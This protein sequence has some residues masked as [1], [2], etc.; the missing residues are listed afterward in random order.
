MTTVA[1]MAASG[2]PGSTTTAAMIAAGCGRTS[3]LFEAAV[4]GGTLPG[5]GLR[6][7]PGLVS[8]AAAYPERITTAVLAEHAQMLPLGVRAVVGAPSGP[9]AAAC[10]ARLADPLAHWQPQTP[11]E[12]LVVDCG[13]V[14]A[15]SVLWPVA[16][17]ADL[18]VLVVRQ[19]DE[20]AARV[21]HTHALA[22]ALASSGARV[23]AVVIGERP[24]SAAEIAAAVG[25]PVVS[26]FPADPEAVRAALRGATG[27][28]RPVGRRRS[29]AVR[30][31]AGAMGAAV[32]TLAEVDDIDAALDV[33]A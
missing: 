22:V 16:V 31:A 27:T 14:S 21:S 2:S 15:D 29:A 17:R 24:Y 12:V 5:D 8:L 13:T 11:D 6:W 18:A 7:N 19:S 32:L 33:V 25:I 9:E 10:M 4:T 28:G 20:T 30:A 23:A 1:V 3:I 26:L